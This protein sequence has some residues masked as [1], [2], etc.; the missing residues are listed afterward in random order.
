M[1]HHWKRP[2]VRLARRPGDD[3]KAGKASN[4]AAPLHPHRLRRGDKLQLLG[5]AA[6][7]LLVVIAAYWSSILD[8]VRPLPAD[9]GAAAALA[10]I[11]AR[12]EPVAVTVFK[13]PSCRCCSG[14]VEHLTR[15]GFAVHV[16]EA[17]DRITVRR[18]AGIADS[19][20]SCHT[21]VVGDYVVEGHVP[22]ADIARLVVERPAIGGLALPGM[23]PGSPGMESTVPVRYEVRAV[24]RQGAVTTFA[25]H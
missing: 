23:P 9:R 19:L 1:S 14:W 16:A 12:S 24:T 8:L 6:L 25:Q 20:A 17:G 4:V 22:P 11:A 13:D 10:T 7:M 5:L 21:A 3:G 2:R 15:A 18:A